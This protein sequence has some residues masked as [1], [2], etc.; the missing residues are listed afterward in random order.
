VSAHGPRVVAIGGGHGLAATLRAV[1]TLTEDVVAIVSVADDGGSSGRLRNVDALPAPGDL[2]KAVAALAA[3]DSM[4]AAALEHRFEGGELEGHAFGNLLITAV[5]G[6]GADPVAALDEVVRLTGGTGRVVPA[7]VDGVVLV[8]TTR[9][10]DEVVGQVNVMAT[11]DLVTI[12]LDPPDPEV[13]KAAIE[14]IERAEVLV[15]GPGSLFTS[16]LAAAVVPGVRD[17]LASAPAPLVYVC[18]L[19]PQRGESE[20]L[21]VGAHLDALARHG[22][23]PDHVLYDPDQIGSAEGVAG[24]VPA[25]LAAANGAAHDPLLLATAL[26]RLIGVSGP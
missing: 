25:R 8:A 15:L 17:A 24:A 9:S 7:T 1:R 6:V 21:G 5:G 10:G 13:P 12:R 26:G 3:P 19:H 18:N 20:G 16:V 22:I 23:V 14:A 2:R 11:A 4:L